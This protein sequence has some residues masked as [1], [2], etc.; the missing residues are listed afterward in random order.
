M[1]AL[2]KA[3]G[4]ADA[5]VRSSA[6]K[7]LGE[8]A[9]V[10]DLPM[11]LDLLMK[12]KEQQDVDALEPAITSVCQKAESP[13]AC[14][15]K[16]VALLAQAPVEQKVAI[17]RVLSGIGGGEALKA[18]RATVADASADAKVH[19]AAI[20]NGHVEDGRRRAR[21]AGARKRCREPD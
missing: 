19:S 2:L 15:P 6:L 11:L 14:A 8:L 12:A 10:K 1:P 3:T 7:K 17:L 18:V 9:G 13:D 21:P 16:L 4:E 5:S 20:R